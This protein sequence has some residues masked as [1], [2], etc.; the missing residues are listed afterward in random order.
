M[1]PV[2]GG[3]EQRH[4]AR[5]GRSRDIDAVDADDAVVN[6][7]FA[8]LARGRVWFELAHPDRQHDRGSRHDL[9]AIDGEAKPDAR[10]AL[11]RHVDGIFAVNL[12]LLL[13]L[14]LMLLLVFEL[15]FALVV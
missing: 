4:D 3:L 8:A 7:D 11:Q 12:W 6:L 2:R 14:R 1:K 5:V 15:G 9:S 13:V 10:L